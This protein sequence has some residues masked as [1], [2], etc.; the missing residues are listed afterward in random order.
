MSVR[1]SALSAG[2]ALP[3]AVFLV[4]ISVRDFDP[5]DELLRCK[6]LGR[7]LSYSHCGNV[8]PLASRGLL[9]TTRSL[10]QNTKVIPAKHPSP[11]GLKR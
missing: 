11:K 5:R 2:H 8:I 7:K 10:N 9:K 4:L 3:P 1:W 6:Q